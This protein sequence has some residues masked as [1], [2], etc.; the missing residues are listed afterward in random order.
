MPLETLMN[1]DSLAKV[2]PTS[3]KVMNLIDTVKNMSGEELTSTVLSGVIEYGGKILLAILVYVIGKWLIRK[4][5]KFLR[6]IFEFRKTD[7]SITKF[8]TSLISITL[9]TFLLLSVIG[10]LGI[11]TTSFLAIF[12]SAGLAIG[13]A[14]SGTLQNF[15]GGVLILTLKPYRTGDFVEVQG[16]TG[17]VKE[18]SL[19]STL[20][21]TVDNKT[22]IVPNGNI[23][24]GIINNY[25]KEE[26]RRVDMSFGVAYGSDFKLVRETLL[27][28]ISKEQLIIKDRD[29]F[30]E[31]GALSD[32]SVDFTIRVW[33][34]T[35]DYW[36]VYFNL[37][38]EVYARFNADGIEFPF[39]QMDVHVSNQ[40]K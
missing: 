40:D 19:F 9:T 8:T 11:N 17:T 38:K 26:F 20:L 16:C 29:I 25:S 22:I 33:T 18:I 35:S 13:M 7:A 27:D 14:L 34:K 28:I 10:I 21:N 2:V 1:A 24:N 4:F 37:N 15:A 39:P 12:A 3:E 36:T 23:L 6:R 30:V 32:S 31:L 5:T